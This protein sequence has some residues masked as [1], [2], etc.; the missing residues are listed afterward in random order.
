MT[1]LCP[2]Q[3]IAPVPHE[4]VL[5]VPNAVHVALE[6]NEGGRLQS[7]R[8]LARSGVNVRHGLQKGDN[9]LRRGRQ[10]IAA[11]TR[12]KARADIGI[13]HWSPA[14]LSLKG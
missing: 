2:H 11:N 10:E 7:L 3:K 9:P 13:S 5:D 6:Q 8:V 12:L 4:H 14:Q 1:E